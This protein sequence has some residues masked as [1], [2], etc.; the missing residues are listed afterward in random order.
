MASIL[1]LTAGGNFVQRQGGHMRLLETDGIESK[2]FANIACQ[3][4]GYRQPNRFF[5]GL[6]NGII[7]SLTAWGF[8]YAMVA[9]MS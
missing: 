4:Q 3:T 6:V 9:W 5:T 1:L 8:V 7:F 2:T